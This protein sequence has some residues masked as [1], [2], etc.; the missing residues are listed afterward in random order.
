MTA[1]IIIRDAEPGDAEAISRMT[2][3]LNLMVG[4]D[5]TLFTPEIARSDIAAGD[6]KF[7]GLIAELD[8]RSAGM[9]LYHAAYETVFAASGY[10]I[11][12]FYVEEF[13]RRQGVGRRLI[14]A[15]AARAKQAGHNHLW[16]LSHTHNE[17]AHAFY[18]TITHDE[19][20][21]IAHALSEGA[22]DALAEEGEC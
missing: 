20:V 10:F 22:F 5:A 9:V 2:R 13:A 12:D 3:A 19:E 18:R 14:A 16:W 21:M 7:Q 15:L 1:R 6:G 4:E 8:D 11:C 17:V